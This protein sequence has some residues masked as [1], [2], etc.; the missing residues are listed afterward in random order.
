MEK[1]KDKDNEWRKKF[2]TNIICNKNWFMKIKMY[3][4]KSPFKR[5]SVTASQINFHIG[6]CDI[7]RLYL[8][9]SRVLQKQLFCKDLSLS[10]SDMQYEWTSVGGPVNKL[11]LEQW[12]FWSSPACLLELQT[13]YRTV[14]QKQLSTV[15]NWLRIIYVIWLHLPMLTIPGKGLFF[16][17]GG[18]SLWI[19]SSQGEQKFQ[20]VS[21]LSH[22]AALH[23]N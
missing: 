12:H 7:F 19:P 17:C 15:T 21:V 23:E 3:D 8:W 10:K 5:I 4:A 1:H 16:G 13:H 11:C 20:F 6:D 18:S 22:P 9:V 14:K 2:Q